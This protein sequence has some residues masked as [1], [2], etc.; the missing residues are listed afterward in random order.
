[1]VIARDKSKYLQTLILIQLFSY[2]QF[3][4]LDADILSNKRNLFE[5]KTRLDCPQDAYL[6]SGLIIR[7]YKILVLGKQN[8][9]HS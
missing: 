9:E 2:L 8:Y 6:Y 4:G 5:L 3:Q 1:M 7:E